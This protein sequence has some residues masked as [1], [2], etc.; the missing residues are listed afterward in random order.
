M[1]GRVL[2]AAIF[3]ISFALA[4][5]GVA[6]AAAYRMSVKSVPEAGAKCVSTATGPLVQGMR[7][8]IWDCSPNLSQILDYDDQ[9]QELK[10]GANCVE[11]IGRGGAGPDIIAVGKC[12]GS[13]SQHWT[14]TAVKDNYQIVSANGLCLE[15]SDG[16]VANG[17]PLTLSKCAP[18]KPAQVW[19]LFQATDAPASASA[20]ASSASAQTLAA[21]KAIFDRHKLIGTFAEDC[22]KDP[23]D[24][25]QY[26]VH[27][28]VGADRIERDQMK[29]R[30]ARS[31][32]AFVEDAEELTGND[33]SMTIVIMESLNAQM[34]GW[35]M[36]LITRLD[37]DRIRLMQSGALTGPYAGRTNIFAGKASGGGGE[38]RWL[39][40]CK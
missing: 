33:V 32:A 36:Q 29:D 4:L 9:S 10:Y 40:R 6:Q 24:A 21:A 35:K 20:S 1:T 28:L 19:A 18:E 7:V 14:M 37:D 27:R 30:N 34:K 3:A 15:I 2:W 12:T 25:N 16:V 13:A 31:Y 17:T 38:T 5:P 39:T 8:F 26:I 11:V 23:S 22:S